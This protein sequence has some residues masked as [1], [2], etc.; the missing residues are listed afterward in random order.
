M[1]SDIFLKRHRIE[2]VTTNESFFGVTTDEGEDPDIK[3]SP[4]W[5][6]LTLGG[7]GGE[8]S[9]GDIKLMD[10]PDSDGGSQV[11]VH[12]SGGSGDHFDGT[13]VHVDGPSGSAKFGATGVE[14]EQPDIEL[15]AA[16]GQIRLGGGAGQ[17]EGDGRSTGNI[18]LDQ[19]EG[20]PRVVVEAEGVGPS[21]PAQN[22]VYVTGGYGDH[23]DHGEIYLK[24]IGDELLDA[25]V[26]L[27]S[28]SAHVR[29][30][31]R[32]SESGSLTMVKRNSAPMIRLG[33]RNAHVTVGGDAE[34]DDG[35]AGTVR[36]R[37]QGGESTVQLD[38]HTEL[39]RGGSISVS[40][41]E[42]TETVS[43]LGNNVTANGGSMRLS[44]DD[45]DERVE[46]Q[47]NPQDANGGEITLTNESHVE[48]VSIQSGPEANQGGSLLLTS[49][50]GG[51]RIGLRGTGGTQDGG[52][53]FLN[54]G[55]SF[56]TVFLDGGA[57]KVKVGNT[58]ERSATGAASAQPG[59]LS[60]DDGQGMVVDLEAEGG[61]VTLSH[62][63]SKKGKVGLELQPEDGLFSVIDGN[64][65]P[66]FQIDTQAKTIKKAK[67]YK[68]G[69]IGHGP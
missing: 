10:R 45:G 36:L 46:L 25:P 11:R 60:L 57:G 64:G 24:G 43:I 2:A 8:N 37:D 66:V 16:D 35:V 54:D 63:D 23:G 31:S 3:L 68:R 41:E 42:G 12:L 27:D 53:M 28:G 20:N 4:N 33:A 62:R 44:N 69:V 19:E 65:D 58:G 40:T 67:Q 56:S 26:Y 55:G 7:G 59:T 5:A 9:D 21:T 30:G 13:R 15:R 47:S 38:A 14:D 52:S 48:T 18:R 61:S 51:Y 50:G 39:A 1:T 34:L 49:D 29:L 22:T 6:T 32:S 17:P